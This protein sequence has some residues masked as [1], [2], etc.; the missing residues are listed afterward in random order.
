MFN[1]ILF[2]VSICYCFM[3]CFRHWSWHFYFG[4]VFLLLVLSL[5]FSNLNF[6]PQSNFLSLFVSLFFPF[7]SCL[8]LLKSIKIYMYFIFKERTKSVYHCCN[9]EREL[10]NQQ[11]SWY[12]KYRNENYNQRH[13][14]KLILVFATSTDELAKK[15]IIHIETHSPRE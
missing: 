8:R 2:Q 15:R 11:Q 4:F 3:T 9:D 13:K 7:L 1:L 5:N 14:T 10:T 12:P 6:F